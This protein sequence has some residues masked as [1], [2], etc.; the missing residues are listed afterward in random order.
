MNRDLLKKNLLDFFSGSS[1]FG[2]ELKPARD[3]VIIQLFK[4]SGPIGIK[5]IKNVSPLK[6]QELS[7]ADW[8]S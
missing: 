8:L 4:W 2:I 1:T 7:P 6:F 5:K 3:D